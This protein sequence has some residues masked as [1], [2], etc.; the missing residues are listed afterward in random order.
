MAPGGISYIDLV[1]SSLLLDYVEWK[2]SKG[3]V[4]AHG[5]SCTFIHVHG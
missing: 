3:L 5:V 2:F 4:R 1:P